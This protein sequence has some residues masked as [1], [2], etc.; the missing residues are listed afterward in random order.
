MTYTDFTLAVRDIELQIQRLSEMELRNR[1]HPTV[2]ELE[3][4]AAAD[5]SLARLVKLQQ[6]CE[7]KITP[8]EKNYARMAIR[9]TLLAANLVKQD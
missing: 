5:E 7:K 8:K 4:G 9:E 1:I 2:F 6:A 3:S